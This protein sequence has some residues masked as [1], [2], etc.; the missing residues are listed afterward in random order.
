MITQIFQVEDTMK[1]VYEFIR[2]NRKDDVGP[3]SLMTTFPRRVYGVDDMN[4]TLKQLSKSEIVM[5][6]YV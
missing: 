4:K 3:F 2:R 6:E 5:L 1:N